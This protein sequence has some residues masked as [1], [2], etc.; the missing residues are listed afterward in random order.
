MHAEVLEKRTLHQDRAPLWN[1]SGHGK[2]GWMW[3]LFFQ[4]EPSV[5]LGTVGVAQRMPEA[6]LDV[7]A[8]L[9]LRLSTLQ[10]KVG[11]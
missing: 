8:K 4:F 6:T 5:L 2:A 11:R 1:P 7:T 3:S 9:L 10:G